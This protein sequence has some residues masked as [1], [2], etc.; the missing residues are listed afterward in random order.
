[1]TFQRENQRVSA[2]E[3]LQAIA[4]NQEIRLYRCTISG[5]LDINRLL[6]NDENF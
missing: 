1:M 3:I 2:S 6:L 4:A 5:E